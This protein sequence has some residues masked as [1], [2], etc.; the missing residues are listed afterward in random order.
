MPRMSKNA[1][2]LVGFG[3]ISG[4]LLASIV[5]LGIP[6][7]SLETKDY[8]GKESV[9]SWETLN[10]EQ[11][12]T[13]L[14]PTT[15]SRSNSHTSGSIAET[16]K[17]QN[18]FD[19][20][21][22][23]YT[24]VAGVDEEK[25]I[26][27]ID[28]AMDL[29][30]SYQRDSALYVIFSKYADI[31]PVRALSKAQEYSLHTRDQLIERIFH[32]WAIDDLDAALASAQSLSGEPQK[33][34]SRSILNAREDLSLERL[35]ELADELQ[36]MEYRRQFTE[37]LWKTKAQEDPRSAWQSATLLPRDTWHIHSVLTTIAETWVEKEGLNVLDEISNSTVDEFYKNVIYRKVLRQIAE[38]D[39]EKAVAVATSLRLNPSGFGSTSRVVSEL[40]EKWAEEEP[41]QLFGLA[42]S[43]DQRFVSIAKFEALT[44]IARKSPQEAVTL[45]AQVDNPALV[46]RASGTIATQWAMTD[47][48]SSLEWYMNGERSERDSALYFIIQ[49]MVE[50]D[51]HG[52]FKIVTDYPG[53]QGTLLTNS[54]FEI[55]VYKDVVHATEFISF[56]DDDERQIPVT[57]LGQ[58]LA[59]SDFYR[60]LEL[61]ENLPEYGRKEYRGKIISA[62]LASDPF[63]L[64]ENIDQLPGTELQAQV[65]LQLL[66]RDK[67]AGM[68]S[69]KQLKN[70]RSRLDADG[71]QKL[72]SHVL[73]GHFY[74]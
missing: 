1:A 9:E 32:Q 17:F 36:N 38:T 26:E 50:E 69:E 49:R 61:Q 14:T 20:T 23:L 35:Y 31:D 65:A 6:Y 4:A 37:R 24:L 13:S 72:D 44:V 71:H 68:F 27:L 70:L 15:V 40:F 11:T 29:P 19:Q 5:F 7:L 8:T 45:L 46:R 64:F 41:Y 47:P 59:K 16:F 18:D 2:L 54:F 73:T 62:A 55:V 22:A 28:Q 48:N 58:K 51:V 66:M 56:L 21:V 63:Y 12:S 33:T 53:D 34:A 30:H 60:A 3:A 67:D 25:V 43:L 74:W 42:D 52:T 39:I 57:M 10:Q